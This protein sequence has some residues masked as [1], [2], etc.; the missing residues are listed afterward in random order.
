MKHDLQHQ[1]GVRKLLAKCRNEQP[2]GWQVLLLQ[3]KADCFTICLPPKGTK[4]KFWYLD[5]VPRG[6][7]RVPGAY[8]RVHSSLLQMEESLE[9]VF[10][11]ICD[12]QEIN[13]ESASFVLY[14]VIPLNG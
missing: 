8:A 3:L 12:R 2:E 6:K 13:K 5:F 14:S 11:D 7:F 9:A 10:T 4:N 1:L